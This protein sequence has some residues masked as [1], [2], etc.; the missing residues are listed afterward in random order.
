L[1]SREVENPI[2]LKEK[3]LRKNL[4]QVSRFAGTRTVRI[5]GWWLAVPGWEVVLAGAGDQQNGGE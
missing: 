4:L 2:S 1:S 5:L 3:L